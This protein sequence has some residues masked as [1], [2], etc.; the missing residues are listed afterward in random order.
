MSDAELIT[1]IYRMDLV[2]FAERAMT[3]LEPGTELTTNWHHRVIGHQLVRCYKGSVRRLVINQPPK[4]LKTHLVS[5]SFVAW[6]LMHDPSLKIAIL[7]YDDTLASKQ[8]E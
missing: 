4:T 5:V 3:I 2:F 8:L 6:L 7:C 1:S